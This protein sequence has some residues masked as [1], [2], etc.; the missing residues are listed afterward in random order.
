MTHE[1]EIK[2]ILDNAG[3]A[4]T[5]DTLKNVG[6][7]I[8]AINTVFGCSLDDLKSTKRSELLSYARRVW[9]W[10]L[11]YI[12]FE[13][14]ARKLAKTIDKHHTLINYSLKM[15]ENDMKYNKKFERYIELVNDRLEQ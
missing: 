7:L 6:K 4:Y 12:S 10:Y 11:K 8:D 13:Y 3:I 2:N 15:F 9:F 5:A 14:S 1:N